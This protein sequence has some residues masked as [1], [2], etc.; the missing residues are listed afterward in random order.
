MS[1]AP[2]VLGRPALVAI[3]AESVVEPTAP[4][5]RWRVITPGQWRVLSRLGRRTRVGDLARADGVALAEVVERVAELVAA[6]LVALAEVTDPPVDDAA[7]QTPVGDTVGAPGDEARSGPEA[8]APADQDALTAGPVDA[9]PRQAVAAEHAVPAEGATE[10]TGPVEVVV[11]EQGAPVDVPEGWAPPADP[12]LL[13]A[14]TPGG[15]ATEAA[16]PEGVAVRAA[17]TGAVEHGTLADAPAELEAAPVENAPVENGERAATEWPRRRSGPT[18]AAERWSPSAGDAAGERAV[19]AEFV[20][21]ERATSA[22]VATGWARRA[23][24]VARW[25]APED[26]AAP[27]RPAPELAAPRERAEPAPPPRPAPALPRVPAGVRPY[28][29]QPVPAA[30]EAGDRAGDGAGDAGVSEEL[31]LPRREPGRALSP[32]AAVLD[33]RHATARA[34]GE[35]AGPDT[36]TL[37]RLLGSL[38]H[39]EDP[40][41]TQPGSGD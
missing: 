5:W 13:E 16:V 30:E 10:R 15:T 20:A 38:Q 39:L 31:L 21:A 33:Q 8:P 37:R 17:W 27:D 34:A 23:D 4:R 6:G 19:P 9:A 12:E 28:A 3:G 26:S 7:E 14:G 1:A 25:S 29:P 22:E 41:R 18:P 24:A 40:G 36:A 32:V 11:A 35:T 2:D